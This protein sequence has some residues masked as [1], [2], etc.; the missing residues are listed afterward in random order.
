MGLD[1]V[2]PLS[3]ELAR[4]ELDLLH[5]LP[6]DLPSR[7]ILAAIQPASHR[8]SLGRRRASDQIHDGLVISQRLAAPIR[9]DERKE[10]VLDLVPL[11]GAGRKV[12]DLKA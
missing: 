7:R 11:T 3:V 8:Q 1:G 2:V 6:G 12:T 4:L 5:L 10:P 9:R